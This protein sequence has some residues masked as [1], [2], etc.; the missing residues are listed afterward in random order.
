M[1][2]GDISH[3]FV[4]TP[5]HDKC[6]K[7]PGQQGASWAK[8]LVMPRQM[9][10]HKRHIPTPI[11]AYVFTGGSGGPFRP[12]TPQKPERVANISFG[13]TKTLKENIINVLLL[14]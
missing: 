12:C 2:L 1:L 13:P 8:T 10:M 6:H 7:L 9:V 11:E 5:C 14:A 3:I 4:P